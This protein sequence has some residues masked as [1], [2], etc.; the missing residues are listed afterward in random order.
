MRMKTLTSV[1]LNS[2]TIVCCLID[3]RMMKQ[4]S[5]TLL[6][7][8]H[9]D[10]NQLSRATNPRYLVSNRRV[11]EISFV[12][13]ING[14]KAKHCT[15]MILKNAVVLINCRLKSQNTSGI[16]LRTKHSPSTGYRLRTQFTYIGPSLMKMLVIKCPSMLLSGGTELPIYGWCGLEGRFQLSR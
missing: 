5:S 7:L 1:A 12:R 14:R 8:K 15:S 16:N 13:I 6:L 11:G 2:I 10:D 4:T 9:N 3:L